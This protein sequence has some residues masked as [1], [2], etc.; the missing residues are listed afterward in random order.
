[1]CPNLTKDKIVGNRLKQANFVQE[2]PS[3]TDKASASYPSSGIEDASTQAGG[4]LGLYNVNS[5]S[6]CEKRGPYMVSIDVGGKQFNMQ[7][8]TGAARSTT[9][10]AAYDSLLLNYPLKQCELL[11]WS[12]LL[13]RDWLSEIKLDWQSILAMS[14]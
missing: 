5:K 12:Y 6:A 4:S 3:L 8:D 2:F 7:L 11:L 13:G 9:S 10:Q 14:E 1:M